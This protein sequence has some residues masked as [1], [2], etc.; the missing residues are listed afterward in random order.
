MRLLSLDL[1]TRLGWAYGDARLGDPVSGWHKLPVTGEDIG[2]FAAAYDHWLNAMID[3][4]RPDLIV[5][6]EPMPTTAGRSTLSTTLKLQGLCWHT[7]FVA[8]ARRVNVRQVH[9][10]Q[11]KKHFC[12]TGRVSKS[13][14]P[15]PPIVACKARGWHAVSD[16]NE[17]DALGIWSFACGIAAPGAAHRL[18]PLFRPREEALL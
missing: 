12:G 3:E 18:D 8:N 10:S 13:M 4:A 16:D 17:A 11:W 2:R 1:A 15:Y 5:F 6:E 9:A 14:K 7:E